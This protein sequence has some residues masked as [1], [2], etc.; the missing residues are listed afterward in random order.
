MEK[1]QS[2]EDATFSFAPLICNTTA[3]FALES[4][5]NQLKIVLTIPWNKE[6]G[7]ATM[8]GRDLSEICWVVPLQANHLL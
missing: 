2:F 4:W 5:R 1:W 8:P 3:G 7:D 6:I